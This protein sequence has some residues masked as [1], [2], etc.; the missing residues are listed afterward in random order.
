MFLLLPGEVTDTA[1]ETGPDV[2]V[3]LLSGAL[4]SEGETLTISGL[5][6]LVGDDTGITVT[7]NNTLSVNPSDYAYLGEGDTE[8][9]T[10]SYKIEE[11]TPTVFETSGAGQG[12]VGALSVADQSAFTL[13]A[14]VKFDGTSYATGHT[15]I[16]EFGNDL[17]T[18]G[19]MA[20]SLHCGQTQL[21][22]E[23]LPMESG[24]ML[25]QASMERQ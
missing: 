23:Q 19:C 2:S 8:V 11:V 7:G 25:P 1:A 13:E 21:L 12:H 20:A 10:Y 24:S 22:P 4:D 17:R 15:T 5:T 6:R 9:I 18:L 3:D 16:L 14:W